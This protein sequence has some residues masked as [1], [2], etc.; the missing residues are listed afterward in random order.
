MYGM[1]KSIAELYWMLKNAE[2]NIKKANPV[3]LVQK[4]KGK[5]GVGKEKPKPKGKVGPQPKGNEPKAPKPKPQKEGMC[6]HCNKR[7]H[8]KRNCPLYLEKLKKNGG[9]APTSGIFVIEVN[10][11]ISIS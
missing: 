10:L 3:L 8:W 5:G 2:Q 7:G 4:G 9:G 1:D 6:F 11:S